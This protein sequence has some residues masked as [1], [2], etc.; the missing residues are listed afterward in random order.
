MCNHASSCT[1]PAENLFP[2][3]LTLRQDC[4]DGKDHVCDVTYVGNGRDMKRP[5][6]ETGQQPQNSSQGSTLSST[7]LPAAR[8]ARHLFCQHLEFPTRRILMTEMGTSENWIPQNFISQVSFHRS[9]QFSGYPNFDTSPKSDCYKYFPLYVHYHYNII[10]HCIILHSHQHDVWWC[11]S[12][13][14]CYAD[15]ARM[16]GTFFWVRARLL[17]AVLCKEHGQPDRVGSNSS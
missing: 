13:A 12:K 9:S 3:W 11:S 8:P 17:H 5:G 10:S 14:S 4:S 16:R 15:V 6:V 1:V 2:W 7:G